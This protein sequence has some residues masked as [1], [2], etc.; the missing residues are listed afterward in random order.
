MEKVG[1]PTNW[2]VSFYVYVASQQ[3]EATWD[4]LYCEKCME[5]QHGTPKFHSP[6]KR[7]RRNLSIKEFC[8]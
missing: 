2:L 6:P 4:M 7:L 1:Q 5:E 3:D 8:G